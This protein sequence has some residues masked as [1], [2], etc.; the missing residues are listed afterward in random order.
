[1]Y[2]RYATGNCSLKEVARI[3]RADGLLYRKSND[4]VGL[5]RRAHE[6]FEN[7]PVSEKGRLL[8]LVLS[9]CEWKNGAPTAQ[10]RQPFDA[11]AVAVAAED[12]ASGD[13]AT[14]TARNENWLPILDTTRTLVAKNARYSNP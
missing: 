8:D 13:A 14:D 5:V 12:K 2:E 10:Y 11:L 6:Q 7:Q 3:A 9:N 4:P 1:M